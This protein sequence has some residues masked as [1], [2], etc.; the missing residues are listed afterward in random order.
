ML[1]YTVKDGAYIPTYLPIYIYI[2]A[3]LP[4]QKVNLSAAAGLINFAQMLLKSWCQFFSLDLA[5]NEVSV[6]ERYALVRV[7][8]AK[9]S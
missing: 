6:L 9:L 5:L 3:Y 4:F 7:N 1:S 2:L 8:R